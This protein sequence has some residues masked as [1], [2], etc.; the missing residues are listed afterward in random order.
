LLRQRETLRRRSLD[1]ARRWPRRRTPQWNR[2]LIQ[3]V[4]LL[5]TPVHLFQSLGPRE[6]PM[7]T[8]VHQQR[9]PPNPERCQGD[10]VVE[11]QSQ[12][13]MDQPHQPDRQGLPLE[14]RDRVFHCPIAQGQKLRVR[15]HRRSCQGVARRV[16]SPLARDLGPGCLA[17]RRNQNQERPTL[18]EQWR[19]QTAGGRFQ[20]ARLWNRAPTLRHPMVRS[21]YRRAK[22]PNRQRR[23]DVAADRRIQ[24]RLKAKRSPRAVQWRTQMALPQDSPDRREQ[25]HRLWVCHQNSRDDPEIGRPDRWSRHPRA[26]PV[27]QVRH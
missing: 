8:Q 25:R 11:P 19:S 1:S 21:P 16:L 10:F 26:R 2:R 12:R 14:G 15:E 22:P 3:R 13:L 20:E 5:L 7:S 18:R 23:M 9:T 24:W 27:H 17:E 4:L 6:S